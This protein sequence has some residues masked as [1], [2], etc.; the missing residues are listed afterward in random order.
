[1]VN[2][3]MEQIRKIMSN[4]NN[5]RNISIIAHV[6]HGKSTLT[7]SLIAK[8]G[9]ISSKQAGE[10]RFTDNMEEEKNRGITIKSTGVS[11]YYEEDI[12]HN[13][14]KQAYI[15]NLI[16]SPG[17]VDFSSEV[18]AALRVTDGAL[19]VVDA[20]EGVC[21]QT[22]T[23]LR[24]AC[25]EKIRPVLMINKVDRAI[26]ET[27]KDGETMYQ[28]FVEIIDKVNVTISTYISND[29]GDIT[30]SPEL[31]NVAFGAGKD[32]WAFTLRQFARIYAKKFK[33][34]EAK[35]LQKLWG[36][37]FYDA[38]AKKWRKDALSEDG[39]TVLK[40]GFVEF[41]LDPIIRVHKAVMFS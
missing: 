30:L 13:G 27:Q 17:H 31:G 39:K 14:N 16:D 12:E 38:A 19:V 40:R 6:D 21:V 24:Q 2:F 15:V 34:D 37:N 35:M 28:S 18:T 36:D 41:V 26:L 9:L 4:P 25:A 10:M 32:C 33:C 22:E 8:T 5:I 23:V 1:M 20:V 29:M 7:D 11:L 3:T